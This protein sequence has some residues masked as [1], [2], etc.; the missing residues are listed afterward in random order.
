[1]QGILNCNFSEVVC[2]FRGIPS[3]GILFPKC[4][5]VVQIFVVLWLK[6]WTCCFNGKKGCPGRNGVADL[7]SG[8]GSWSMVSRESKLGWKKNDL[9]SS[10]SVYFSTCVFYI[11][12]TLQ[13]QVPQKIDNEISTYNR[14]VCSSKSVSEFCFLTAILL[15]SQS[16]TLAPMS[17]LAAPRAV[18][19]ATA[20]MF[21][22]GTWDHDFPARWVV[23]RC[24][25][26]KSHSKR[27]SPR[28]VKGLKKSRVNSIVTHFVRRKH[29]HSD[30][31]WCQ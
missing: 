21:N 27:S 31:Y 12:C 26:W 24:L 17:A 4:W 11:F 6:L 15:A 5:K 16:C 30:A 29:K 10:F 23:H 25:I 14:T 1:M 19:Y 9:T 18:R 13:L 22:R 20:G 28:P 7:P 8:P 2:C 3:F